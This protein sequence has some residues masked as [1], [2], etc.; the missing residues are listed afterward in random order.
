MPKMRLYPG[1]HFYISKK[2]HKSIL[3]PEGT[4]VV[5][6]ALYSK[7]EYKK[8]ITLE[9]IATKPFMN[10]S[11]QNPK[12]EK[13]FQGRVEKVLQ[14]YVDDVTAEIDRQLENPLQ[15]EW[16]T[17]ASDA[18]QNVGNEDGTNNKYRDLCVSVNLLMTPREGQ[19]YFNSIAQLDQVLKPLEHWV[20]DAETNKVSLTYN[21]KQYLINQIFSNQLSEEIMSNAYNFGGEFNKLIASYTDA[22]QEALRR[23]ET[24]R[25]MVLE[26]QNNKDFKY[27]KLIPPVEITQ[28]LKNMD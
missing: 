5:L 17:A 24:Y 18:A 13:Q 22:I 3:N 15:Y 11:S 10:I 27:T 8:Q 16:L 19:E 21:G 7:P 9:A 20:L 23:D 28:H 12:T 1:K 6:D 2:T 4:Q 14:R 25:D 26:G